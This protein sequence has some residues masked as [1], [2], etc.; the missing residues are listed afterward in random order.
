M[1]VLFVIVAELL[2]IPIVLWALIVLDLVLGVVG[3]TAGF[4]LG[5]RSPSEVVY[6][7]WKR[8]VRRVLGSFALLGIALILVDLLFFAPLVGVALASV[9]ERD[10]LELRYADVEGSFILGRIEFHQLEVAGMRGPAGDPSGRFEL[11]VDQLVVDI[12]TSALLAATFAVEEL[13]VDGVRGRYDRLRAGSPKPRKDDGFELPREFL[14]QRLH[15]GDVQLDLHDQTRA[16]ERDLSVTLAELDLGP[17]RSDHAVFDLLYRARGRG[18][19]A[20]VAF[21]LSSLDVEGQPQM[22][23]DVHELPLDQ[24]G[25]ALERAAG[26]RATGSAELHLVNRYDG[27]RDPPEIELA[28]TLTLRELQ[29]EPGE[30]ATLT[31][32]V[33]LEL[34]ERALGKLGSDLPLEFAVR[35]DEREL[36]GARSL[37]ESGVLEQVSQALAEALRDKLRSA[38]ER[39][40]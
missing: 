20:G 22:I 6:Y 15:V 40:G 11:S 4:L 32:K 33:M 34:A 10:D 14:V 38:G 16:P 30:R 23:L 8:L 24:L 3:G 5:R 26:V 2:L 39:E 37:V 18:S 25:A 17:L 29:L 12:D 31:S 27:Q 9:D 7:K 21:E 13:A 28:V 1:D 35:V 19:I 36:A